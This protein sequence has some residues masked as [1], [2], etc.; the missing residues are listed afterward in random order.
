MKKRIERIVISIV[1]FIMT[2]NCSLINV[3]ASSD[4]KQITVPSDYSNMKL[5]NS[6]TEEMEEGVYV[7][8][9]IYEH[10][11]DYEPYGLITYR[12]TY[13]RAFTIYTTNSSGSK[14]RQVRFELE[15]TFTYDGD[16]SEC[17]DAYTKIIKYTAKY[18]PS[19]TKRISE[20]TAYGYC[21]A[22]NLNTGNVINKTIS[23]T[24]D[25][26]GNVSY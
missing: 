24:V 2:I 16:Y 12:K 8:E 21:S 9:E 25:K 3:L 15:A 13:T 18:R 4:A 17:E 19:M 26:D 6:H 23:I 22:T 7:C 10:I 14:I 1:I 20:D 5:I 11:P